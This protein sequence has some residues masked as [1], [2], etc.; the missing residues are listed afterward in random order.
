MIGC[1]SLDGPILGP[2]GGY[3]RDFESLAQ[4]LKNCGIF[5]TYKNPENN[6]IPMSYYVYLPN[7]NIQL[8]LF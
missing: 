8:Y 4:R 3:T 5:Q 1:P 7:I 6:V 2:S